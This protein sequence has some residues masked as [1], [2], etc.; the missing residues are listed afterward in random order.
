MWA[1]IV[2]A[3]VGV[4]LMAAPSV[5]GYGGVAADLDRIVGPIATSFAVVAIAEAARA[6]RWACVPCGLVLIVAPFLGVHG[7]A[8]AINAIAAGVVLIGTAA[9]RGRL[10]ERLGG[11]W[12]AVWKG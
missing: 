3:V 1:R 10:D 9:V 5:L 2:S 4:W 7:G 6:V 8:A 11:G 12:R